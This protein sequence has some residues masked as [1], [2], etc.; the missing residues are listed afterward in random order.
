MV[1]RR[2]AE[3]KKI[4][5]KQKQKKIAEKYV[6]K[7]EMKEKGK[8]ASRYTDEEWEE[9]AVKQIIQMNLEGSLMLVFTC[10]LV[11]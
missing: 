1:Y 11:S 6:R 8:R 3:I 7:K 2:N 10:V 5:E 4:T 9:L